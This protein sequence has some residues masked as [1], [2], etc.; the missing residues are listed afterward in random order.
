MTHKA[1]I[2]GYAMRNRFPFAD[3]FLSTS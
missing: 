3:L 1:S 2:T